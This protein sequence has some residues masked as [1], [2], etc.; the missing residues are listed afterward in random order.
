MVYK[1]TT[2]YDQGSLEVWRKGEVLTLRFYYDSDVCMNE[3]TV[4]AR[5]FA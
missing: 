3:F 2:Q 1:E 4:P 5:V